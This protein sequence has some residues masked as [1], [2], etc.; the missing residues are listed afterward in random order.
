MSKRM[1]FRSIPTRPK[2]FNAEERSVDITVSTETPVFM[3]GEKEILLASGAMFPRSRSIPLLNTHNRFDIDSILGSV[4]DLRTENGSVVGTAYFS[5]EAKSAFT[6]VEEGHITD[7]SAGYYEKNVTLL[8]RGEE[9]T[10][11]KKKYEGPLRIVTRWELKEASLAPIGVDPN[12]KIRSKGG[13]IMDQKLQLREFLETKGLDPNATDEEAWEFLQR[14]DIQK[15]ETTESSQK[16]EEKTNERTEKSSERKEDTAEMIRKAAEEEKKRCAEITAWCERTGMSD[17]AQHYIK[18][19]WTIGQVTEDLLDQRMKEESPQVRFQ[20]GAEANEKFRAAATDAILLRAIGISEYLEEIKNPAPGALDLRGYS[21]KE[22]ARECLRLNNKRSGGHV[23]EMVGRAM[24]SSDFPYILAD[25]ARKALFVGFDTAEETWETWCGVGEV[26]DFKA[27]TLVRASEAD[28][29]D[30]I[31]EK[32]EYTYGDRTEAKETYQITTYGKL[33]AITRQAII[34]DDLNAL[35]DVPA[36]HGESAARKIG[37][38]PY[39]VLTANAAMGDGTAL[40][41]STHFNVGTTGAPSVTTIAEAEKLMGTQKDL[42]GLRRLNIRPVYFIGPWA[43][44]GAT[45]VFF[46]SERF[47]AEGTPGTPDEAYATT[48]ANPYSGDV[49]VRVYDARLD[50]SSV[51]KWYMAARKGKSINVYFLNGVRRPYLETK[52]G[53]S[54]DGVEYKVRIDAAAKA[55]HWVGLFYNAGA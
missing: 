32:Q 4:R 39:A 53:W 12:S 55:V 31:N 11:G 19:G 23:L 40:F 15:T 14:M 25:S 47:A 17:R 6:K 18:K 9:T 42:R 51:A 20:M 35:T 43:L 5:E 21:L 45:E 30:E 24:T 44:K 3:Y 13:E 48:R 50:A 52:Q 16:T 1:R 28:D 41:D 2:T 38:L 33:F 22:I 37:D 46:R 8:K 27:H 54:V 29:L 26:S 10:I 34:N 36:S 7:V 49:F